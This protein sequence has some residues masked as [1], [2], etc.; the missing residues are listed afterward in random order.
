MSARGG[1]ALPSE[2]TRRRR[3]RM[4]LRMGLLSGL[5]LALC[6]ATDAWGWNPPGRQA[7][8][9]QDP[10]SAKHAAIN[11]DTKKAGGYQHTPHAYLIE[12]AIRILREDGH[13]NWA[14]FAQQHHEDLLDG[15][16]YP[17]RA[18]PDL[19][20]QV[21]LWVTVPFPLK[22][23]TW[24][25]PLCNYASNDHYF[26]PDTGKGLDLTWWNDAKLL[27][28]GAA[29]LLSALGAGALGLDGLAFAT[30]DIVP[31]IQ[32]QYASGIDRCQQA[33][34]K[35]LQVW[36]GKLPPEKGR[37]YDESAMFHLGAA[38]HYM[39]DLSV[40]PH[41]YDCFAGEHRDYESHADGKGDDASYHA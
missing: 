21:S 3:G 27:A 6:G 20:I 32:K 11:G 34:G 40:V 16:M 26:N 24:S 22:V 23:K 33:Y 13:T 5:A 28:K 14:A 19:R 4:A 35:A 41:T 31:D 39:A 37:G 17:D 36:H 1:A 7:Q 18:G 29:P 10:E 12:H 15:C 38:C 30:V 9:A 8:N 2:R 25:H